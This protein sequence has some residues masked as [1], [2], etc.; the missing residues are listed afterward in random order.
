MKFRLS[1]NDLLWLAL[2]VVMAVGWW[3]DHRRVASKPTT[4]II[5]QPKEQDAASRDKEL[6][7]I[8]KKMLRSS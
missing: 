5:Y 8:L 3:I 2:V 4:T 6:E 7:E 1:I